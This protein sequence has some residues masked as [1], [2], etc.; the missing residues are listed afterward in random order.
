MNILGS[1]IRR[2]VTTTMAFTGLCLIGLI[3]SS[4]LP[5]ELLP[6][7]ELPRLTVITPF[8]NAAPSEV[9]KLVTARI[10][11][12]VTGV[13]G[14]TGV[15]S[16]SIEGL[17]I[18]KIAFQW[19]TDMDM[20]LVETKEKADLVKGELPEDTGQSVVVRYDPADDPVMIYSVSL[21]NNKNRSVRHR[22]EK[23]IVPYIERISGVS[24]VDILGGDKREIHVD[25]DRARL[26]AHN[27]SLPDIARRIDLSNYNYPAGSLLKEDFM[28]QARIY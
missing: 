24:L 13:S 16:E 12:A 4:R 10:E 19:G 3:S 27:L 6:D 7:I 8:E 15:F 26:F 11:E 2:R 21:K 14:V 20:A 9:E 25:I 22:T 1:A 17:S 18:V 5:V 23:E 28:G